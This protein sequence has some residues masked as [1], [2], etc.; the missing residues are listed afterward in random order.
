[1]EQGHKSQ[2]RDRVEGGK[3]GRSEWLDDKGVGTLVSRAQ[4]VA[5]GA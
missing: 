4:F 5:D 1:M 3:S 2:H